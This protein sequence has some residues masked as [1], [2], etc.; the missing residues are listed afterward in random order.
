MEVSQAHRLKE[1]EREKCS[2]AQGGIGSDLGQADPERSS[3]GEVLSPSR[4]RVCVD[5]VIDRLTVSERRACCT[6]GQ[7]RSTQRKLS[8]GRAGAPPPTDAMRIA[9]IGSPS[10]HIC[11]KRQDHLRH[12]DS[13][14]RRELNNSRSGADIN[15]CGQK[16]EFN[17]DCSP[18]TL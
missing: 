11:Q 3:D 10:L 15:G 5:H 7:H 18:E 14:I 12:P 1:L 2:A 16:P 6:L 4:R 13:A 17:S 9:A 8:C